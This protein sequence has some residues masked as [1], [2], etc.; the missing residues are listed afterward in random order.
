M[1]TRNPSPQLRHGRQGDALKVVLITLGVIFLLGVLA[2]AGGGF[3]VYFQFQKYL[4]RAIITDP[5]EIK[6]LSTEIVDLDLPAEFTPVMGS[7]IFGLKSVHY[8][9]NPS[10]QAIKA[11]DWDGANDASTGALIITEMPQDPAATGNAEPDLESDE[12][13]E[14]ETSDEYLKERY[15]EFTKTERALTLRGKTCKFT[16]IVGRQWPLTEIA[17]ADDP[18]MVEAGPVTTEPQP[19]VAAD[20][21]ATDPASQPATDPATAPETEKPEAPVAPPVNRGEPLPAMR[22]VTG[23]FPSKGGQAT[24]RLRVPAEGTTDDLLWKILQ[25][26]R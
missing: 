13:L 17:Q 12:D 22:A 24:I 19:A 18:A 9:W 3:Y 2:C 14:W 21:P 10:K 15:A 26:I 23:T 25:S 4:G 1:L 20:N 7:A 8:A 11:D 16:L 6:K 5:L